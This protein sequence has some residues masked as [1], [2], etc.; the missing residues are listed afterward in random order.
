MTRSFFGSACAGLAVVTLAATA[1]AGP[2]GD[3]C[4]APILLNG[5]GFNFDT[6]T[7]TTDGPSEALCDNAGDSQVARDLWIRW[8][9]PCTGA[10]TVDVCNANYDTK[11]ALYSTCPGGPDTALACNDDACGAGGLASSLTF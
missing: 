6:S 8:I 3:D 4:S 10:V 7:T 5:N 9:A 2:E 1:M 11:L